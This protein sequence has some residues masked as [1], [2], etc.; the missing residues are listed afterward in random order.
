MPDKPRPQ[1]RAIVLCDVIYRDEVTK[2]L[3]LVGTF[4]VINTLALPCTHPGMALYLTLNEGNGEYDF[5]IV[6]EHVETGQ[7]ILETRG[8]LR[9][10]NPNQLIEVNAPFAGIS[11][12]NS[13]RYDIQAWVD[14]HLIGQTS[15]WVNHVKG[16]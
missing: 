7:K 3:I 13:G 16:E 12:V 6:F 1:C 10:E 5:R 8:P 11:F 2:K 9:F 15:F 14:D 4:H